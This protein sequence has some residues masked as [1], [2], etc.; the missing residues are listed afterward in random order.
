MSL[1]AT[2]PSCEQDSFQKTSQNVHNVPHAGSLDDAATGAN[3]NVSLAHAFT[4][5]F[6]LLL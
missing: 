5:F 6:K 1:L 2:N 4:I 3:A